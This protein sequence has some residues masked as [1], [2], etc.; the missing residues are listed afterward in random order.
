VRSPQCEETVVDLWRKAL[1]LTSIRALLAVGLSA[2][3]AAAAY[4]H[5]VWTEPY[6][7]SV[8]LDTAYPDAGGESTD[9]V[10]A[11]GYTDELGYGYRPASGET[12]T[13]DVTPDRV[14]V[15]PGGT[16]LASTTL[17]AARWFDLSFAEVGA[18]YVRLRFTKTE[19]DSVD[20]IFLDEVA[21]HGA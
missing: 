8:S 19:A 2:S 13:V 16:T 4:A 15:L 7:T 1:Y 20:F 17:P 12:K 11:G 18:R 5:G 21:V 10:G 3:A 14:T 9:G 6:T